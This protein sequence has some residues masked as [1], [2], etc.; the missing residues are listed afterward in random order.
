LADAIGKI[1]FKLATP[2]G[3][4]RQMDRRAFEAPSTVHSGRLTAKPVTW[5]RSF[6]NKL[7]RDGNTAGEEE[8]NTLS[9]FTL[10][11]LSRPAL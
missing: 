1:R 3:A 5:P 4:N 2:G 7:V 11:I 9:F 6:G 10:E 8:A